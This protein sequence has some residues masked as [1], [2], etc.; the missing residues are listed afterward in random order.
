MALVETMEVM[1]LRVLVLV[2]FPVS[3]TEMLAVQSQP[4]VVVVLTTTSV[5]L[6]LVV[7]FS[8]FSLVQCSSMALSLQTVNPVLLM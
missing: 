4:E 5:L 7:V 8:E 3:F 6:V 1:V 2:P